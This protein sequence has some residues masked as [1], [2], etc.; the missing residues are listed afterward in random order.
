VWGAAADGGGGRGQQRGRLDRAC[1]DAGRGRRRRPRGAALTWY[2]VAVAAIEAAGATTAAL[3]PTAP[4]GLVGGLLLAGVVVTYGVCLLPT[5]VV[6]GGPGWPG[7]RGSQRPPTAA[8]RAFGSAAV[9]ALAP[10]NRRQRGRRSE[11][12]PGHHPDLGHVVTGAWHRSQSTLPGTGPVSSH[13][14]WSGLTLGDLR[15]ARPDWLRR[16]SAARLI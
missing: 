15:R 3:L 12:R 10:R 4:D 11:R 8:L 2:M 16:L 5:W 14:I 7:R 13:Q 6:A 1:R 9:V